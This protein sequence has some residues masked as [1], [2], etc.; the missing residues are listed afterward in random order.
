MDFEQG[1]LVHVLDAY[2][3]GASLALLFDYDGTLVPIAE[4]PRLAVLTS[5]TRQRLDRLARTPSAFVGVLSGRRIDDLK[6]TVGVSGVCYVGTGGLEL[7][8][9]GVPIMHPES[10]DAAQLVV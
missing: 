3:R 7:D 5:E 6:H 9:W 1:A 8:L 2:R 10:A 4:H